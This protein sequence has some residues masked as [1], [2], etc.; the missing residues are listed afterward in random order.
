MMRVFLAAA[1]LAL[2]AGACP[3]LLCDNGGPNGEQG[4]VC[5]EWPSQFLW[6]EVGDDFNVGEPGWHVDRADF[7]VVTG[8]GHGVGFVDDC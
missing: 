4:L 3:D 7:S 8:E 1:C 2:P 6:A 5:F